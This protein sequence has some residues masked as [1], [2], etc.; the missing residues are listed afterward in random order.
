[1]GHICVG[2]GDLTSVIRYNFPDILC[3][4][5]STQIEH[6]KGLGRQT[7]PALETQMV[8]AVGFPHR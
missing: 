6:E 7:F 2:K 1:M 5:I 4:L 8:R 3:C